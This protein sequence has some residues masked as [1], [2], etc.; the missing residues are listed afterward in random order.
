MSVSRVEDEDDP[1]RGVRWI[2]ASRSREFAGKSSASYLSLVF[3]QT[4][5]LLAEFLGLLASRWRASIHGPRLAQRFAYGLALGAV[6]CIVL[7]A[8]PRVFPLDEFWKLVAV[9]GAF[10]AI[11]SAVITM[12][13]VTVTLVM[14]ES[15]LVMFDALRLDDH[16]Y[17]ASVLCFW[18]LRSIPLVVSTLPFW[19][20]FLWGVGFQWTHVLDYT[21]LWLSLLSSFLA[22]AHLAQ[23]LFREAGAPAVYGVW[24][25]IQGIFCGL[26]VPPGETPV[27]WTWLSEGTA[28]YYFMSAFLAIDQGVGKP[29]KAGEAGLVFLQ[30]Q[31]NF[32]HVSLAGSYRGLLLYNVVQWVLVGLVLRFKMK[33]VTNKTSGG[34]EAPT[35]PHSPI[36]PE[37]HFLPDTY[38]N[39]VSDES[40]SP[41]TIAPP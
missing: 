35:P 17:A 37:N 27:W 5:V 1:P 24:A 22:S 4:W 13:P 34:A 30:D 21:F 3:S 8:I 39:K 18:V 19:W 31:I 23:A 36:P 29:I 11:M 33:R 41:L 14:A 40:A 20:F 26:V 12:P 7:S 25:A 2:S 10:L 6:L 15:E 16:I 28:T 9:P 38:P 32:W